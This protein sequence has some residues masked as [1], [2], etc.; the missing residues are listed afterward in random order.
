MYVLSV[1]ARQDMLVGNQRAALGNLFSPPIM[2][3]P[4]K[5]SGHQA[6]WPMSL[7]TKSWLQPL[8]FLES[9][10]APRLCKS[11]TALWQLPYRPP[12]D[13]IVVS[14]ISTFIG[15]DILVFAWFFDFF[16]LFKCLELNSGRTS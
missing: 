13:T 8:F 1:C 15:T 9:S 5:I 11:L 6:W 4:E 12:I 3:V 10:A 16:F 7:L 2:W 14:L